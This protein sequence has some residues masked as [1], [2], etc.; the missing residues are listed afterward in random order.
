M[1]A[2]QIFINFPLIVA[3]IAIKHVFYARK[4]LGVAHI[5]GLAA[6]LRKIRQNPCKRVRFGGKELLNA[7]RLQ[8]E[9]WVNCGRRALSV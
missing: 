8:I 4:G 3:G 6:G 9:L 2:F 1:P 7:F 5:K